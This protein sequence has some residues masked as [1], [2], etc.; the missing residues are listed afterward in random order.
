MNWAAAMTAGMLPFLPGDVLKIAA[1]LPIART[2]RPIVE[3]QVKVRL[4]T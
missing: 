1:A 3:G 2:L 4:E